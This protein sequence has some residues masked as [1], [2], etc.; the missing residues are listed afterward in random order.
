M[1]EAESWTLFSEGKQ[2]QAVAK[3][4]AAEQ[5]ERDH[6]M[7]YA[8]VLPRPTAEMVGD[9]LMEMDRPSEA[10][11]AYVTA[12]QFAPKRFDSLRGAELA[13]EKSGNLQLADGYAKQIR[14][15]DGVFPS[16]P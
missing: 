8:D 1:T 7:Y 16:E 3:L 12:L 2:E 5:Y 6:P 9:I 10:L 11:A 13:A 4:A 15:E 14:A